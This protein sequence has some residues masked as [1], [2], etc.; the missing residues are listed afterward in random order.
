ME[1]SSN[2][3]TDIANALL[4]NFNDLI[5]IH[6]Y[7]SLIN[8]IFCLVGFCFFMLTASNISKFSDNDSKITFK[9]ILFIFIGVIGMIICYGSYS[10]LDNQ[11][12]IAIQE[13]TI[14]LQRDLFIVAE[15]HNMDKQVIY[16]LAQDVILCETNNL[17]IQSNLNFSFECKDKQYA[18]GKESFP[19]TFYN[20][21]KLNNAVNNQKLLIFQSNVGKLNKARN[22][23]KSLMFGK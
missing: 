20:I 9:M 22:S 4:N 10:Y 12:I 3:Y 21:Q 17:N 23:Q 7:D 16:N 18:M 15:K 11:R 5:G 14:K 13:Q 8:L 6:Q 19:T 2:L 1:N